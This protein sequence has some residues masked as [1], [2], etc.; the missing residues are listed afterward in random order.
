MRA[1]ALCGHFVRS[2]GFREMPVRRGMKDLSAALDEWIGGI[3]DGVEEGAAGA[4]GAERLVRWLLL[5]GVAIGYLDRGER[6][7]EAWGLCL[8]S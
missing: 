1:C 8:V 2:C 5:G 6:H 3:G 4:A 7:L